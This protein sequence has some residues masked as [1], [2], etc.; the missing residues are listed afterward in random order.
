L[1]WNQTAEDWQAVLT[2][3]PESCFATEIGGALAA[4]TTLHCYER[5]LGWIGMVLARPEFRRQGIARR[6]L[7]RVLDWAGE[8]GIETVK[9]DATDQGQPLYE[10]LGFRAERTVERWWRPGVVANSHAGRIPTAIVPYSEESWREYDREAFGA[11]RSQVLR[12]LAQRGRSFAT[13]GAYL[14]SRPGRVSS[15]LGPCVARNRESVRILIEQCIHTIPAASW[16]WDLFPENRNAVEISAGPGF[17]RQRQLLRMVR[18]K[19]LLEKPEWIY[20]IA[21]FELG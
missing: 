6:L 4:T 16:A 10:S 9:L 3:N 1:T 20:A 18:G 19:D 11:D 2:L 15:Y 13:E 8:T 14:C 12:L 7:R 5:G 17:S 21:G